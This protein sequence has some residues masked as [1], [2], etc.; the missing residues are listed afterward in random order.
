M[1]IIPDEQEL[2]NP[3]SDAERVAQLE[4]EVKRLRAFK[5]SME[6][7]LDC[8]DGY[9]ERLKDDIRYLREKEKLEQDD[10][11]S[12]EAYIQKL[13]KASSWRGILSTYICFTILVAVVVTFILVRLGAFSRSASYSK[14]YDAGYNSGYDAGHSVGYDA[15]LDSGYDSGYDVGYSVGRKSTRTAAA[16][17]QQN[18][19]IANYVGDANTHRLHSSKCGSLPPVKNQV[20]FDTYDEGIAAGYVP[21]ARCLQY[22]HDPYHP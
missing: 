13:E 9:I 3:P 19:A 20:P 12:T 17:P 21:C 15:G 8:K 2:F 1:Q 22:P 4:G 10:H 6:E 16:T 14:G 5:K 7:T 18:T 11:D